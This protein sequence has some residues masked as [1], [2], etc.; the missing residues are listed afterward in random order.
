MVLCD[1]STCFFHSR[2][3]AERNRVA[4]SMYLFNVA[5]LEVQL[6]ST[7]MTCFF[8]STGRFTRVVRTRKLWSWIASREVAEQ[9]ALEVLAHPY[10]LHLQYL[11]IM[12]EITSIFV[13]FT[14]ALLVR[15]RYDQSLPLDI[16]IVSFVAQLL[17]EIVFDMATLLFELSFQGFSKRALLYLQHQASNQYLLAGLK[18]TLMVPIM[19]SIWASC[20]VS[21]LR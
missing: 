6:S 9:Q 19:I 10:H 20:I 2:K 1:F 15:V 8:E 18:S 14:A 13:A 21:V 5:S 3:H 17:A 16:V 12:L 11:C 7:L 4:F